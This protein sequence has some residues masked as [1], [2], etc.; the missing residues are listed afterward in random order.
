MTSKI[1]PVYVGGI[2]VFSMKI[3]GWLSNEAWINKYIH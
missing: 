2:A 3:K 1:E